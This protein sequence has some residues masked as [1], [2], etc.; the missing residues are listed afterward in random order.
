MSTA[1]LYVYGGGIVPAG[2]A[3]ADASVGAGGVVTGGAVGITTGGALFPELSEG[4]EV[5]GRLIPEENL[6]PP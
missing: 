2:F 5:S 1:R 6:I 3:A 4:V